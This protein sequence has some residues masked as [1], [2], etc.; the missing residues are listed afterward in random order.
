MSQGA[1]LKTAQ[2]NICYL[3]YSHKKGKNSREY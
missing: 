2:N 3:V 1:L